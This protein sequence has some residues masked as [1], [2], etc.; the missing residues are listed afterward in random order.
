MGNIWTEIAEMNTNYL[1]AKMVVNGYEM[2]EDNGY[3]FIP[4]I[5]S[6]DVIRM[7]I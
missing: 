5:Y 7:G 6:L 2:S 4:S 3:S 1:P